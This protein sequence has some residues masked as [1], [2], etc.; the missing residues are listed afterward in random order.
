MVGCLQDKIAVEIYKEKI[1]LFA[2]ASAVAANRTAQ[3]A[4]LAEEFRDG[5]LGA[6]IG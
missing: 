3:Q 6:R 2:T 5:T 4:S 1:S